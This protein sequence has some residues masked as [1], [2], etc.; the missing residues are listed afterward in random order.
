MATNEGILRIDLNSNKIQLLEVAEGINATVIDGLAIHENYL[1]GHQSSK[2][3][4][5]YLN[6]DFS[7]I[8]HM[9]VFD[10]GDE[11][12]SSTTGEIGGIFYHY[13]VNSLIRS[14]VNQAEKVIIP[15]DSLEQVIIRKKKIKIKYA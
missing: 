5:F 1:I 2:I 9:E 14:G 10:T 3:S 13:I 15:L 8:T 4:K 11:F 12:D 7:E 6:G